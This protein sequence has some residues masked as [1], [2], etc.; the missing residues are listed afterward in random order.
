MNSIRWS[1]WTSVA[2]AGVV[3]S[4][5]A[6]VV[7]FNSFG[8]GNTYDSGVLW[9]ITGASTSYG[10]RGQAEFFTPDISGYLSSILLATAREGGSG[11]SNFYLARD[12]RCGIPGAI[13]E[14]FKDVLNANGLLTLNSTTKP[15]LRAGTEYWICDV[16]AASKSFNGWCQNSLGYAPGFAFERSKWD[17]SAIPAAHS[18]DSGV[19]R[20]SVTP[21]PEPAVTTLGALCGGL[22]FLRRKKSVVVE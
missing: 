19:F 11:Y 4:T 21:V 12:N 13:L 5:Q 1:V 15:L 7:V 6:Q 9:G 3:I 14:S 20:V 22:L 16:P 18:P 10:Y 8:P 2:L 17:W